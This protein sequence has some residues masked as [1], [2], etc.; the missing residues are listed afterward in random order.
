MHTTRKIA[1]RVSGPTTVCG[2]TTSLSAL[3][4]LIALVA[5][6]AGGGLRF[7]SLILPLCFV[8][9]A[10]RGRR[11]CSGDASK[12]Q[13]SQAIE[14][15]RPAWR[16]E[17][18]RAV[19]ENQGRTSRRLRSSPRDGDAAPLAAD[20]HKPRRGCCSESAVWFPAE[21]RPR[22][23]ECRAYAQ[24]NDLRCSRAIRVSV[25]ALVL[26]MKIGPGGNRQLIALSG[27]ANVF[28]ALDAAAFHVFSRRALKRSESFLD[29]MRAESAGRIIARAVGE[30]HA[31]RRKR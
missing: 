6:C 24:R 8:L 30:Q 27:V 16:N 19:I 7:A 10:H 1:A 11:S 5:S 25:Y 18:G 23:F 31:K 3:G 26:A 28:E 14:G 9:A 12:N 20:P 2:R 22:G 13:T 4:A 21:V 29:V 17:R 15:D